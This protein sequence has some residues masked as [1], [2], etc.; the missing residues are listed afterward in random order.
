MIYCEPPNAKSNVEDY[1]EEKCKLMKRAM[2]ALNGKNGQLQYYRNMPLGE[3]GMDLKGKD[4][5][6]KVNRVDMYIGLLETSSTLEDG[7]KLA[8]LGCQQDEIRNFLLD[9]KKLLLENDVG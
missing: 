7:G 3:G 4:F 5:I 6:E 8:L 1:I 2:I 9:Y